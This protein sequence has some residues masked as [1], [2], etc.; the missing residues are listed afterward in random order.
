MSEKLCLQWND[1]KENVNSAF[2]KLRDNKE[3]TD[4]TLICEDGQQIESHKVILASS[5]PFFEKIL[6]QTSKHPHPVIYLKGFASKDFASILDFLF[7]GEAKVYQ[8]DL[9]SFLAIAEEIKLKGLTGQ[10]SRELF[11]EQENPRPSEPAKMDKESYTTS[12]TIKN[13]SVTLGT[14][15]LGKPSKELVVHD[16][17]GTDLQT[18]HYRLSNEN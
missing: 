10:T 15:V 1:F 17:S 7:F 4:V 14:D 5:S 3:F 18:L 16:Q 13:E 11:E 9:D 2:G 12:T 8:E 6:Q